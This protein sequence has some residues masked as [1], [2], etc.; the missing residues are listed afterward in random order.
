LSRFSAFIRAP[1]DKDLDWKTYL[2]PFSF[3]LWLAVAAAVPIFAIL[4]STAQYF[5]L[6]LR[7]EKRDGGEAHFTFYNSM[8]Y[9]FGAFCQQGKILHFIHSVVCLATGP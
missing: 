2:K 1:E 7:H 4:L 5:E 3:K 6:I 8:F 9:V